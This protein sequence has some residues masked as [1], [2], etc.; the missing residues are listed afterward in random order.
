MKERNSVMKESTITVDSEAVR[1]KVREG[2]GQIA[3]S[4][5]CCGGT[6]CCGPSDEGEKV[7]IKQTQKAKETNQ[8]ARK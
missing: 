3:K 4:G 7:E 1:Q 5:G 6:G 2:Y 8:A